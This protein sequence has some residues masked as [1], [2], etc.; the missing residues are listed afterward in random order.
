MNYIWKYLNTFPP[1]IPNNYFLQPKNISKNASLSEE[2]ISFLF[3]HSNISIFE[4][5][6]NSK[7]KKKKDWH[8]VN[9]SCFNFEV[10]SRYQNPAAW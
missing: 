6:H 7:L 3:Y 9:Y 5:L 1:D 10:S 2:Q 8:K 4:K